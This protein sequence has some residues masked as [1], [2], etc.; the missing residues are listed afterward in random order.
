VSKHQKRHW[1]KVTGLVKSVESRL[2]AEDF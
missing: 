2:K 1:L